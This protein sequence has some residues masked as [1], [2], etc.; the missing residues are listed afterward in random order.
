MNSANLFDLSHETLTLRLAELKATE[1]SRRQR[2]AHAVFT[3]TLKQLNAEI[4]ASPVCWH[5]FHD[6]TRAVFEE[7]PLDVINGRQPDFVSA[8]GSMY[9]RTATGVYRLSDHW[10]LGIRSCDWYLRRRDGSKDEGCT[11]ALAFCSYKHFQ[12][13]VAGNTRYWMVSPDGS[14]TQ[15]VGA[16][17]VKKGFSM[18]TEVVV[19]SIHHTY[20]TCCA[21]KATA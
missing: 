21:A 14:E 6:A 9:W 5:N 17:F 18:R 12:R 3:A 4:A 13:D 8:S 2:K 20:D 7:V 11:T 1:P 10:G 15:C 16:Q 19:A